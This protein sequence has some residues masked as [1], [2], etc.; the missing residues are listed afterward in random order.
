MENITTQKQPANWVYIVEGIAL[1]LLGLGAIAWPGMTFYFFTVLFGLYALVAG[2]VNV[3]GGILHITK[4]W[5]AIGRIVLGG[6]LVAAGS[7]VLNHPG[8]TA[9]TLVVFIGFTFLIR[10][11]YD[12][13]LAITE[14]LEHKAL[15][16]TSGVFGIL[17]GLILLRYPVGGGLAYVWVLGFYALV[18]GPMMLAVGLGAGKH[19][20][21]TSHEQQQY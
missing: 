21:P 16:I 4:G 13:V 7:Y 12:I 6:L 18:A 20:K 9:V 5:S 8:I 3:I 2:V 11:I 1:L 10:G 19:N 14:N 15:T 17:A